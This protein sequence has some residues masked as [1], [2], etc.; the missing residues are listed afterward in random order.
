VT[1]AWDG[2][3]LDVAGLRVPLTLRAGE[4]VL[5]LDVFL[6]RSLLEVYAAG[7]RVCVSRVFPP[8]HPEDVG[9][10]LFAVGGKA[11]VS[12]LSVWPVGSI[13]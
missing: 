11:R 8:A 10:E 4:K 9:V 6:D 7:G 3:H 1:I 12:E 13:W 5:T 2:S